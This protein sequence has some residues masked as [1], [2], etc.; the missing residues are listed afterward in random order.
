[1]TPGA[2]FDH[3]RGAQYIRLSFAGSTTSVEQ[4]IKRLGGWLK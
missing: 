1:V 4:A 3:D 2:D